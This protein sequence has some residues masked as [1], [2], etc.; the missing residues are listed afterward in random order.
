MLTKTLK[1]I[2]MSL[3]IEIL[4]NKKPMAFHFRDLKG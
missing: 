3:N 2:P 4:L 1:F